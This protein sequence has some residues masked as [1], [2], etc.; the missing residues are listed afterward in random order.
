[1]EFDVVVIGGGGGGM[2]AAITATKQGLKVL[3]TEK[4][5]YFGG[6]TAWSGGG[7]WIPCN[8]QM[9][10]VG[11]SDTREAAEKYI[12]AVIGP[13][14]R[15]DRLKAFLDHGPDMIDY[16]AKNTGVTFIPRA[17]FPDYYAELDGSMVGGRSL[18]S[19]VYDG[20]EL[21]PWLKKLRPPLKEFNA[22]LG[23]MIGPLDLMQ[24]LKMT[25][26]W[27]AFV[28][29][30][31]LG[32]RFFKDLLLYG[33]ATRLTMGAALAARLLRSTIDAGV[34]MWDSSPA[35]KLVK[36]G[37]RVTGVVIRHEGK[38][39]TVRT[40]RG[41]VIATGGFSHN[42]EFR[43]R[44]LPFPQ[45]HYSMM[46]EGNAGDGL[47]MA[48]AVGAVMDQPNRRNIFGAVVSLMKKSDG[49]VVRCPHFF[50]DIPKPGCIAV[51]KSG[52]RFGDEANLELVFAMHDTGSVP[53]YLVCDSKFLYKYGLGMVWPWALRKGMMLRNG[54]LKKGKTQRELGEKLGIDAEEF[55]KTVARFNGFARSGDDLDFGRGKSALD[56]SLGDQAN[57]PNP[58]LGPIENGPFY[59]VEI[60]PGDVSSTAGLRADANGQAV[61]ADDVPIPGL[62]VCG[63]DANSLWSGNG[64]ANG[65]YNGPSLTFGYI[66]GKHLAQQ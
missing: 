6:T 29:T 47:A 63:N 4:S 44:Y 37:D 19:A 2:A 58:C 61:D 38:D 16:F 3:L 57:R 41:V 56:R 52:K 26:S 28:Y 49:S 31:K 36:E 5:P 45:Q 8:R 60:F 46:T 66:I 15:E 40:R 54:Y 23:M 20:R 9:S 11:L 27:P 14:L 1:M 32:L 30:A 55:E 43:A 21:G 22:P 65:V 64:L 39:I 18:G 12:R 13:W 24:V 59:A 34:T 17:I 7:C 10:Q 25:S 35:L 42:P 51:N 62:Y 50:T 53:A 33:R 48:A